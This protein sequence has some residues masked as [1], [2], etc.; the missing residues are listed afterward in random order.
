M[1]RTSRERRRRHLRGFGFIL[2]L[3]AGPACVFAQSGGERETVSRPAA[4]ASYLGIGVQE[5][6]PQRAHLLGLAAKG[7]AEVTLLEEDGPAAKAGLKIGDVVVGYNGRTVEGTAQLVGLVRQTPPG[8]KVKLAVVRDAK[9]MS[10]MVTLGERANQPNRAGVG[11]AGGTQAAPMFVFPSFPAGEMPGWVPGGGMGLLG[12]E[13]ETLNA[14]L[15]EYFGVRDGVLVRMVRRDSAAAHAGMKAGDVIQAVD[16]IR[17][18]NTGDLLNAEATARAGDSC[19]LQIM[20]NKRPMKLSV[21]F[22][23]DGGGQ[24][25][26]PVRLPDN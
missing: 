17:V 26:L 20:R 9:L 2:L 14:Q 4:G 7:G 18:A 5:V 3:C 11:V 19:K 22:S 25:A 23:G 24:R 10:V 8:R 16:G 6:T 1:R 12:I 15:A 21:E 13:V